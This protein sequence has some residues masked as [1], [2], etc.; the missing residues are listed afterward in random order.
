MTTPLEQHVTEKQLQDTVL[1]AATALGWWP[2]HAFDS[3]RSNAGWVDLVL[4]KPPRA[5]FLE[6]KS[7][8]GK[9]SPEQCHV[10]E[11][12]EDCGFTVGVYRPAQLDELLDILKA[13]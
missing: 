11:M 13:R 7:R 9:V 2:Y 5:L 6:L 1:Q 3:R 10:L 12:L 4:L 8:V